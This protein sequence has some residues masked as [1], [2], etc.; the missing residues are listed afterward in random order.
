MKVCLLVCD[1]V[2]PELVTQHGAYPDMFRRVFPSVEMDPYFVCDS[3][4]PDVRDF[5]YFLV[6]GSKSSVYEP[7]DWIY[8]LCS[9]FNDID[10]FGKKLVGVCFGHQM[11]A[12]ALGGQVEK[13][14]WNIGIQN[15]RV[16]TQ[17][18]WM[19]PERETFSTPMLCQDQITKLPPYAKVLAEG[20]ACPFGMIQVG[21]RFL[22]IQG[23]PEFTK[24]YAKSIYG[25]R[26]DQIGAE[27]IEQSKDTLLRSIDSK[28]FETWAMNFFGG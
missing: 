7:Q 16:K 3:I 15:F 25:L 14:G 20:D 4:F 13:V 5:D 6:T 28:L 10:S 18:P 23:H 1:H 8:D 21:E 9:F 19:S 22:G 2:V 27:K 24:N 17:V 11:I 26:T 12:H